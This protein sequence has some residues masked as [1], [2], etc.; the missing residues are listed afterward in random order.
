MAV[1]RATTLCLAL[2]EDGCEPRT[3]SA[4]RQRTTVAGLKSLTSFSPFLW[5]I[6]VEK[7]G[8]ANK[9]EW[10]RTVHLQVGS[11]RYGE[12]P[13]LNDLKRRVIKALETSELRRLVR[14][15]GYI[16]DDSRAR[17]SD[18]QIQKFNTTTV[19]NVILDNNRVKSSREKRIKAVH[20]AVGESVEK[21]M[22]RF[23]EDLNKCFV[24][25]AEGHP[26]PV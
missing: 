13:C 24:A 10:A 9:P 5:Q 20:D 21:V 6:K 11:P 15:K 12:N 22:E 14:A 26:K 3:E 23:R 1:H 18:A 4:W 17:T 7:S 19:F 2:P 16:Y 25:K 8:Q